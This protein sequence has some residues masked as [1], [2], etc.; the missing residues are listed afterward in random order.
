[1]KKASASLQNEILKILS[2]I[3]GIV[4]VIIGILNLFLV[5][6]VPGIFYLLLSAIYFPQINGFIKKKI[7]FEIPNI[8][9][10]P[11]GFV[12]IWGTLAVG[13]L[14]EIYGL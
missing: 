9:K 7:G 5:H 13:E 3:F 6:P 14:A 10:L 11:L 4:F 1:M 8:I 2:Y 12:V